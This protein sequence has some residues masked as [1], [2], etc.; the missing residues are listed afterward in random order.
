MVALDQLLDM[1]EVE[2]AGARVGRQETPD[3]EC[4]GQRL[5]GPCRHNDQWV[6]FRVLVNLVP[7]SSRRR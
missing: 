3:E 5:A 7:K 4:H 1:D 6:L 2:D